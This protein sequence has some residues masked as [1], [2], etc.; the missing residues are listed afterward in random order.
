VVPVFNFA[1]ASPVSIT[2]GPVATQLS[3]IG[4][5]FGSEREYSSTIDLLFR[6]MF[7]IERMVEIT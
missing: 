1:L 2:R 4:C 7:E 3:D 5:V 6:V